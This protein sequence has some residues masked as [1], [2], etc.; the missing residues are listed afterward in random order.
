MKL[1]H[2]VHAPPAGGVASLP[3]RSGAEVDAGEQLAVLD[4]E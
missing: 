1:G 3:V 4:A 2:P